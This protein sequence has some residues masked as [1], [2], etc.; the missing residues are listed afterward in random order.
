MERLISWV[1]NRD[2][3][4]L[5]YVNEQVRTPLLDWWMSRITHLGGATFTISLLLF[6]L[7]VNNFKSGI[8][9]EGLVALGA[10]HLLV[11][12]LKRNLSRRRPYHDEG[13]RI[14]VKQ[15]KDYSFPSG[16][17]TAIFSLTTTLSL[18]L[19][20]LASLLLPIACIVGF[21]RIYLGHH[22][23]TDVAMGAVIGVTFSI[24]TH[25]LFV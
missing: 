10:S 23:S 9:K 1:V 11:Q 25:I 14:C 16:H 13:L 5:Y 3:R 19:P 21:S 4:I 7:I 20:W 17:T 8:G 22:Y 6:L 2:N 12:V 24:G 18:F 15:L